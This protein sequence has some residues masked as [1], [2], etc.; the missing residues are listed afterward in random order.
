[1]SNDTMWR[2][3]EPV[4]DRAAYRRWYIRQLVRRGLRTAPIRVGYSFL[5]TLA[6]IAAA[7]WMGWL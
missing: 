6:A 4:F 3:R 1:M 2:L 7:N 5:G